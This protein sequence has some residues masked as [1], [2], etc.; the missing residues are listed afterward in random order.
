MFGD[1]GTI[2]PSWSARRAV[3]AYLS[4]RLD[5]VSAT[6]TRIGPT[7][8]A[9]HASCSIRRSIGARSRRQGRPLA[10]R[11][12]RVSSGGNGDIYALARATPGQ[13]PGRHRGDRA[14][15]LALPGR[16][17]A[18]LH[19]ERVGNA[20]GL[21]S[22]VPG[23]GRGQVAGVHQRR[24]G[25]A[26][27]PQRPGAV[28]HQRK[29]RDGGRGDPGGAAISVG[30]QRTLFSMSSYVRSGGI[31]SYDVTPDDKRFI[32]IREG[33]PTQQSELVIAEHWLDGLR[34]RQR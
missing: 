25:A 1:T 17:V 10:H 13:A 12:E 20:R 29:G 14:V 23:R 27:G 16:A 22:A 31:H 11:A 9:P 21:R 26:L 24:F 18:G 4:D 30:E 2:R 15:S 6:S 19:L 28:L 34:D 3:G 5:R 33:D 7:A 32:V 8:R